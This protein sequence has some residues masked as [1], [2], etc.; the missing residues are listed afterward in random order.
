[1]RIEQALLDKRATTWEAAKALLD[2]A[3]D[4]EERDL[5]GEEQASWDAM[6]VEIGQFDERLAELRKVAK[7]EAAAN[8]FRD[9]LRAT[10][11]TG[12]I[13]GDE[14]RGT[15]TDAM[16]L[17]ALKP[18]GAGIEFRD[19]NTSDDSAVI[20]SAFLGKLREHMT[21]DAAIFDLGVTVIDTTGGEQINVPKTATYP[22]AALIA[23][24]S[25]ITESE[26]T[27]AT[28]PLNAYKYASL[29]QA[30]IEFVTDQAVDIEEHL[31]RV[32]GKAIGNGFGADAMTGDGSSKPHGI[33][34]AATSGVTGAAATAG[35]PTYPNLLALVH[36]VLR[37]YRRRAKW[38]MSDATLLIVRLL[39]DDNAR[40]LWEPSVKA[41]EPD[42]LAG[43][44]LVVDTNIA[45]A[46]ADAVSIAYGDFSGYY[47]RR[48]GGVLISASDDYAFNADLRTFK[49][50]AR[51]DGALVDT[52]AIKTFT[53]GAAS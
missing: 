53:G 33:I 3:T 15:P 36:S 32:F 30:S 48:A 14:D 35:V 6:M 11:Q 17:R 7:G 2:A 28:V 41:G 50:T 46:A 43:Y 31:A 51:L 47:V 1:M 21:E 12:S 39:V 25:A 27:F 37:P 5:S 10:A 42:L 8:E 22:T 44:P 23:E 24:G 16:Q 9:E 38:A 19:L 52:N 18:G 20:K 34:A 4:E 13:I 40:P 49:A 26:G 29:T 45:D